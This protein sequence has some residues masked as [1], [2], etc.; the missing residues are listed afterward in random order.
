MNRWRNC[1]C[2][3]CAVAALCGQRPEAL[4]VVCSTVCS[5]ECFAPLVT[6]RS[7]SSESRTGRREFIRR[8]GEWWRFRDRHGWGR[9]RG[10]TLSVQVLE[11]HALLG[12]PEAS[13]LSVRRVTSTGRQAVFTGILIRLGALSDKWSQGVGA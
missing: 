8:G 7:V 2:S 9:D 6:G 13:R 5:A 1:A 10:I 3:R 4:R 12:L 11:A